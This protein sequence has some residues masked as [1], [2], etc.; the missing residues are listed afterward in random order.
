MSIKSKNKSSSIESRQLPLGHL[1]ITSG[2]RAVMEQCFIRAW[3]K[4]LL[5]SLETPLLSL[6]D[7]IRR[8]D[9]GSSSAELGR[10]CG[11]QNVWVRG[12][13]GMY[14]CSPGCP[15]LVET[16]LNAT[17]QSFPLNSLKSLDRKREYSNIL[18]F[19]ALLSPFARWSLFW[20]MVFKQCYSWIFKGI[21]GKD[22]RA[23]RWQL[24]ILQDSMGFKLPQWR[25][26]TVICFFNFLFCFCSPLRELQFLYF[27]LPPLW[28]TFLVSTH[29][30]L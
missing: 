20:G 5:E 6:E 14:H 10:A 30:W 11:F 2:R 25:V 27:S 17:W 29:A 3:T 15:G 16:T 23:G 28:V 26:E 21:S 24:S 1:E 22:L 4:T 8:K 18:N 9:K 7:L 12:G 19:F 13:A